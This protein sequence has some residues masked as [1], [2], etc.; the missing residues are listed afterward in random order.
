[1][2]G[3]PHAN[4]SAIKVSTAVFV[5]YTFI[6]WPPFPSNILVPMAA[7]LLA[8]FH[9]VVGIAYSEDM[10]RLSFVPFTFAGCSYWQF[11]S[12]TMYDSSE[13]EQDKQFAL[14]W[15]GAGMLIVILLAGLAFS[16]RERTVEGGALS[17]SRSPPPPATRPVLTYCLF[18]TLWLAAVVI[19]FAALLYNSLKSTHAPW[20]RYLPAFLAAN[21]LYLEAYFRTLHTLPCVAATAIGTGASTVFGLAAQTVVQFCHW[22]WGDVSEEANKAADRR[23]DWAFGITCLLSLLV[24]LAMT[25]PSSEGALEETQQIWEREGL[26]GGSKAKEDDDDITANTRG[27]EVEGGKDR[28]GALLPLHV[29]GK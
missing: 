21:L 11:F 25:V 7:L 17:D 19:S 15:H 24:F 16:V 27:S 14:E 10:E 5:L 26:L 23:A 13:N 28:P 4:L 2:I 29:Q 6:F 18:P 8:L 9:G 1:M 3:S 22:R 20:S 12:L